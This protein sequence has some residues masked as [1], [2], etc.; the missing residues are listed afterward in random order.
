MSGDGESDY[1]V[2][3]PDTESSRVAREARHN[4][5]RAQQKLPEPG[6]PRAQVFDINRNSRREN[7]TAQFQERITTWLMELKRTLVSTRE[8]DKEESAA[9]KTRLATVEANAAEDKKVSATSLAIVKTQL[10]TIET[11][12]A[13]SSALIEILTTASSVAAGEEDDNNPFADQSGDFD[14]D[15]EIT[16]LKGDS[17]K[18]RVYDVK[19]GVRRALKK[20][21]QMEA[22]Q[23]FSQLEAQ[24]AGILLLVA[25]QQKEL[26]S[27]RKEFTTE[28]GTQRKEFTTELGT[29]R[30]D[31][32][33][34][35]E[36]QKKELAKVRTKHD[37]LFTSETFVIMVEAL[38]V[39]FC[40]EYK[41]IYMPVRDTKK[42]LEFSKFSLGNILKCLVNTYGHR[43]PTL[44]L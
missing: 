23:R 33:T 21:Q 18:V 2:V 36:T 5:L 20:T 14:A 7:R 27:Q 37:I 34:E 26:T 16:L 25:T 10:T 44:S 8:K 19:R 13:S 15:Y 41:A 17:G 43:G 31:F 6:S 4:A 42:V 3:L 1:V 40:K 28:L 35:L 22:E 38:E 39:E 32:T 12:L 29:Q 11:K 9:I 30:K 24:L